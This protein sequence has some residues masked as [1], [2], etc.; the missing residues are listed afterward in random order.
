MEWGRQMNALVK[1]RG[2]LIA[3][4]YPLDPPRDWGPPYA[5]RK[6]DYEEVL[7]DGWEIVLER[8]PENSIQS[9]KGRERLVVWRKAE[10]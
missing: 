3:L 7:G 1:D 10:V 5:V 4:V 8:V 2:L 9:H 6:E